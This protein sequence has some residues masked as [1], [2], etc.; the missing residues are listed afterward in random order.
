MSRSQHDRFAAVRAQTAVVRTIADELSRRNGR[1]SVG[2]LQDQ[3]VEESARLVAVMT[4]PERAS[5]RPQPEA[6]LTQHGENL[7]PAASGARRWMLIVDDE[8]AIRAALAGWFER[9]YDVALA[10]DGNEGIAGATIRV[11]DIIVT[12][13]W[14]PNLD[15]ISMVHRIKE[16][17]QL[18]RVPIVFLTGRTA[19]ESVAAGFSVGAVSYLAKPVDLDLLDAEVLAALAISDD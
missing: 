12:D 8:P 15:G 18:A 3:V 7:R 16:V 2:G 9:D 11:P 4:D 10:C 6:G 14:M 13:V 1:A 19:P 5:T 17:E